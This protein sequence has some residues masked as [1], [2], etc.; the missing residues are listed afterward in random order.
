M[1]KQ[2]K[3]AVKANGAAKSA[4]VSKVSAA[5]KNRWAGNTLP[6]GYQTISNGEFGE[7]W[8]FENVPTL[9]G[10]IV[11]IRE[12]ETGTGR[13]K[14][15]SRVMTVDTGKASVDVWE[16]AAL[17][18]FFDEA[19]EGNECA[20]VFQGYRDLPGRGQP[21]KVFAAGL[22]EGTAKKSKARSARR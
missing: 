18:R 7:R 12:V 5:K 10:S 4:R 8:D 16:S 11:G 13:N 6:T 22:A 17:K 2:A 15:T 9:E 19:D 20:I 1:A 21:M 14:R 3:K